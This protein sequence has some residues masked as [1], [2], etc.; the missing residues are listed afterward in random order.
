MKRSK[1]TPTNLSDLSLPQSKTRN[2]TSAANGPALKSAS[3]EK[4][5]SSG[6]FT[7]IVSAD[8]YNSRSTLYSA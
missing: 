8:I 7:P 5:I 2:A 3:C 6:S 4:S 1:S